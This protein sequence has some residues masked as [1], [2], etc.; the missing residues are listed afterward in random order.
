[1]N[2]YMLIFPDGRRA[3]TNGYAVFSEHPQ[4]ASLVQ[5]YIPPEGYADWCPDPGAYIAHLVGE[6]FQLRVEPISR[7]DAAA[8]KGGAGSGNFGHAGRPGEVGGSAPNGAPRPNP[9]LDKMAGS[10]SG[11]SGE[12]SSLR[13]DRPR[14]ASSVGEMDRVYRMD[15]D[16]L[17]REIKAGRVSLAEAILWFGDRNPTHKARFAESVTQ[18]RERERKKI[19]DHLADREARYGVEDAKSERARFNQTLVQNVKQNAAGGFYAELDR[20]QGRVVE[21]NIE[22]LTE[23]IGTL[24]DLDAVLQA[25]GIDGD[26]AG[27]V[28]YKKWFRKALGEMQFGWDELVPFAQKY[29]IAATDLDGDAIERMSAGMPFQEA[30][31]YVEQL[32]DSRGEPVGRYGGLLIGALSRSTVMTEDD[33]VN[34]AMGGSYAATS[35]MVGHE[36]A[37]KDAVKKRTHDGIMADSDERMTFGDDYDAAIRDAFQTGEYW[38]SSGEKTQD[39]KHRV[40]TGVTDDLAASPEWQAVVGPNGNAYGAINRLVA[41]WA[42]SS[43]DNDMRAMTVQMAAGELFGDELTPWQRQRLERIQAG[44]LKTKNDLF[45]DDTSARALHAFQDEFPDLSDEQSMELTKQA[46][47]SMYNRTQRYLAEKGITHLYVFRGTGMESDPGA[48][49][50]DVLRTDDNPLSSWSVDWEVGARFKSWADAR[51]NYLLGTVVPAERVLSTPFTGF[52]CASEHEVLVIGTPE[53]MNAEV[54]SYHEK[55]SPEYQPKRKSTDFPMDEWMAEQ[56]LA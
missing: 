49:T 11:Q 44:E 51:H 54:M 25:I 28:V 41:T 20:I 26:T 36:R 37:A 42:K 31:A 16:T 23:S 21:G 32:D 34:L 14:R 17:D 22:K 40:V 12:F 13:D 53:P 48:R 7:E 3:S 47:A 50:G 45:G 52:G 18:T 43:N 2:S 19:E 39:L 1:M 38:A 5:S 55:Y 24:D 10:A 9:L 6:D 30:M 56:G 27:D 15:P 4:L 35:Q 29:G 33:L 8:M 46:L